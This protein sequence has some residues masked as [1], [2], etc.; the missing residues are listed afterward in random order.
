[1]KQWQM[2]IWKPSKER[3]EPIDADSLADAFEVAD[4][5]I[6]RIFQTLKNS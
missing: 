6:E 5:E 4:D 2:I 3:I 1:M